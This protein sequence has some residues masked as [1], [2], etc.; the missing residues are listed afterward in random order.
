MTRPLGAYCALPMRFGKLLLAAPDVVLEDNSYDLLIGTQ[1]LREYN[2]IIN[3]K[4]WFLSI[5]GYKIPLI[6]EEPI[7]VPGKRL[8]TCLLEYP[9]GIF[10]LK[11]CT[12]STNMKCPPPSCDANEG[13]PLLATTAATIP[14]GSQIIVDSQISYELPEQTFLELYS[15]LPLGRS[16]PHLCPGILDASHKKSVQLLLANMTSQPMTIS[17]GQI[18][19]YGRLLN[20]S[21]VSSLHPFGTFS[22][23]NLPEEEP[24]FLSLFTAE[25]FPQLSPVQ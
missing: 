24:P 14:P 13:I 8:K 25:D 2:G 9:T 7:K 15:P 23:F 10:T 22:D 6:F 21:D 18:V 17:W 5:L 1:F 11:Y 16:E 4:E 12:H 19:G 3:L 20:S